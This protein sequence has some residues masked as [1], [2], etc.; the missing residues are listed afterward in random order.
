MSPLSV[1]S[2]RFNAPTR[3]FCEGVNVQRIGRVTHRRSHI[4][5]LAREDSSAHDESDDLLYTT[6]EKTFGGTP[7]CSGQSPRS[8]D[9]KNMDWRTFRARLVSMERNGTLRMPSAASDSDSWAH[10]ITTIEPGCILASKQQNMDF[11]N[12]AIILVAAHDDVNGTLGYVLNK[13]SPLYVNE[14]HAT[15]SMSGLLNTFGRQRLY[16]GGPVHL[17]NLTCIH[18]YVGLKGAKKISEGIYRGGVADAVELI[19][20]NMASP[21]DFRLVLGGAG[22]APGQLAAEVAAGCWQVLAVG[23]ALVLPPVSD[24]SEPHDADAEMIW[25]SIMTAAE[26]K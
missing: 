1:S 22:W 3:Q 23:Q 20:A 11:F 24:D 4:H 25:T 21:R 13:P 6:E 19:K 7:S 9:A 18:R 5:A 12:H 8:R 16:L 10:P 14:L 26:L 15:G 2:C 17:E